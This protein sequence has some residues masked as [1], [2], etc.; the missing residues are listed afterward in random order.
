MKTLFTLF[1]SLTLS[2]M[3]FSQNHTIRGF[4][5]D[6]TGQAMQDEKVRLLDKDSSIIEGAFTSVSGMFQFAKVAKGNYIIRV[7]NAEYNVILRGVNVTAAAGITDLKFNLAKRSDVLLIDGAVV[8]GIDKR[9]RT[10]V[11]TSE[12][13]MDQKG[14]ERIPGMGAENDIIGA[15]SITP[16][17]TTTGDQGGQLYVRGGT[18]IQNKILLDGMTIY[19]PFHSIGFFSVF[20]TELVQNAKILTGGFNA[21][22][23]G[24]ISSVMD[25]TYR[26]GDRVNYGGKVSASPFLAKLVLEGPVGKKINDSTPRA[27][28]FIFSAKHSLLDYTSKDLYPRVNNGEGMPFNFTDVYGK[29]TFK[30]DGGS[31]FSAFGFHNRDSVNYVVADLDWSSSGG[32]INFLLV[33]N[34]SPILV[35][36]HVTGSNYQTSFNETGSVPRTS[37]IG[38]FDLGFDFTYFLKGEGE[39][40]YGINLAGFNVAYETT[41]EAGRTIKDENFS[42]EIGSYFNYRFVSTRWVVEP[43]IRFQ[44]YASLGTISPEPRIGV[45]FNASD[46]VRL[47]M[48]GGRYSQNFTSASSDKDVVNLFNGLLSAPTNVQETFVTQYQNEKNPKNGLQYAWHAIAGA[49]FDLSK[50]ITLNVE[51]YYKYFSQLSNINQNK[52]YEDIA[53]FANIDDIFK[54]DFILENGESYGVDFL[55]KYSAPRLFLWGVY[56]YGVST[57]WDGFQTYS[58]VFDRRHNINLVGTYLIGKDK[59]MEV[60][61]RW[62]LGSGLPFTPTAGFYQ[63]ENFSGGVTTDITETNPTYVSTFLGGFNSQRL[64]FY[65]RLDLTIK[66]RFTLKNND[67]LEVIGSITNAY[68]RRN[69]FYV[70]RITG[71]QIDQFPILPSV[72]VSYKF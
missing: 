28:S 56:S 58:P 17:V 11:G 10:Q 27:G 44:A 29:M 37:S 70:N 66:K 71:E 25:I 46:K 1:L 26:D 31:K 49:E 33:P 32:G 72:G 55:L 54:K 20:E 68:D 7:E 22:Y 41:N 8:R 63:E 47:K 34:S 13:S 14:L 62:N 65:H 18:P 24:R 64:P 2:S 12:I 23:G 60:S 19:S 16:G 21:E 39:F 35:M 51:G 5:Y 40:N 53:Q 59:N 57:R 6:E 43:S 30:G 9:K 3:A 69:I 42:T 4:V 50:R 61:I 15:F 67:I 36:G 48:S 52:I 38:G 45:K